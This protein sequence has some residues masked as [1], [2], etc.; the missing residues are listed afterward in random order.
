MKHHS[1]SHTHTHVQGEGLTC[2]SATFDFIIRR[3]RLGD[4]LIRHCGLRWK[5]GTCTNRLILHKGLDLTNDSDHSAK[6]RSSVVW[7]TLLYSYF[8]N[9]L[10]RYT[11]W[12][13]VMLH[14]TQ[15]ERLGSWSQP[16]EPEE[17]A[18]ACKTGFSSQCWVKYTG[19]REHQS[20]DDTGHEP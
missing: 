3:W 18:V 20:L 12:R 2:L 17:P 7:R 10:C 15:L 5:T 1:L 9:L 14:N 13:S 6:H 8:I 11:A 16:E 19:M 4:T